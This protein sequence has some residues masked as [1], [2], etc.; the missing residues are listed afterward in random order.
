MRW[1]RTGRPRQAPES[2]PQLPPED[3]RESLLREERELFCAALDPSRVLEILP[4]FEPARHRLRLLGEGAHFQSWYWPV[5]PDYPLVISLATDRFRHP[6]QPPPLEW[7]GC[8]KKLQKL[9]LPLVP[10][11][12]V[13]EMG[14]RLAYVMPFGDSLAEA[15]GPLWQPVDELA[16]D[17][18]RQLAHHGLG[19]DDHLQIRCRGNLPFVVDWSDLRRRRR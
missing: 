9:R 5:E 15:A 14:E 3:E 8:M 2:P 19:L 10:P 4:R 11:M 13:F 17:L 6:D 12:E 1:I 16:A 7:M 18:L